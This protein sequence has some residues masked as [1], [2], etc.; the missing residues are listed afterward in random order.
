M[1][2]VIT[3]DSSIALECL[4]C[5]Q[6]DFLR[7]LTQ[8]L[9]IYCSNAFDTERHGNPYIYTCV[10]IQSGGGGGA[11]YVMQRLD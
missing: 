10:I 4:E 8:V 7:D 1:L 11:K 9:F 5:F 6:S 3:G 2:L